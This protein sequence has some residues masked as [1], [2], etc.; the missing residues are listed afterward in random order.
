MYVLK[1][2]V[3]AVVRAKQRDNNGAGEGDGER[4]K[5]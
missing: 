5:Q 1:V 4:R 3:D 2:F